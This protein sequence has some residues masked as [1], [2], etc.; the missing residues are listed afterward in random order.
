MVSLPLRHDTTTASLSGSRSAP[1][2]SRHARSSSAGVALGG[3]NPR[4][5]TAASGRNGERRRECWIGDRGAVS[6]GGSWFR[7]SAHGDATRCRSSLG[8]RVAENRS[9]DRCDKA[10]ERHRTFGR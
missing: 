9:D 5:E 6:Q 3:L 2:I 10:F 8:S 7:L 1:S 4:R